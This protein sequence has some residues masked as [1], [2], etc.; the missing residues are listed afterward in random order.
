[1]QEFKIF[2]ALGLG[3]Q[4]WFRNFVPFMV[5]AAV[6]YAPV[7]VWVST[8]DFESMSSL[9]ELLERLFVWPIYM[10]SA[11][12]ALLAPMLTYRVVQD[13][14][15]VKVSMLTS[16]RHGVRGIAPAL[17]LG[18]VLTVLAELPAGGLIGVIVSCIYFVAAPAAVAEKL[19]PLAAFSR[20]AE[21]TRGRRP[22]IFGLTFLIGVLTM[23]LILAWIVPML[24]DSDA[25]F[26][27]DARTHALIVVG[28]IGLVQMFSGIVAAVS[29]ALLRRDKDGLSYEH[30]ARVFE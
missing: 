10:V 14:N 29:Y 24:N 19:G 6:L 20:S 8:L 23:A 16:I 3:F 21:L 18:A 17:I 12:A 26:L 9:D 2:R 22:G 28:V 15:G 4:S 11:V 25:T 7:V 13:L 5:L 27:A 1:M 30:L